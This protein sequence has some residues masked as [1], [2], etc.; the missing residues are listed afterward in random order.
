MVPMTT[1]D[2]MGMPTEVT[3]PYD[4]PNDCYHA[5]HHYDNETRQ[6]GYRCGVDGEGIPFLVGDDQEPRDIAKDGSDC[7]G[8]PFFKDTQIRYPLTITGI[9]VKGFGEDGPSLTRPN[10]LVLVSFIEGEDKRLCM[11]ILVGD[12]PLVPLVSHS[13][14]SGRLTVNAMR[15]PA[16][17]VPA[18]GRIVW[19]CESW[20]HEATLEEIAATVGADAFQMGIAKAF[21]AAG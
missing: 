9:D 5:L 19:G 8:C 3:P 4:L 11:G 16:I 18:V 12:L 1:N 17:F 2:K 6:I 13:E 15:N 21:A 10:T 7:I 14:D 20:W